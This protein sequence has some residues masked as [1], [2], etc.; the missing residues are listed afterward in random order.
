MWLSSLFGNIALMLSFRL[1]GII[2]CCLVLT[3]CGDVTIRQLGT[4][5][6]QNLQ[7]IAVQDASGREGQLYGRELRKLLHIGG[8]GVEN[9]DL[10]SS[11]SVSASR[12]LS[13]QGASSTLKK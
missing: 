9:Y 10:I 12:T 2:L 13:V 8:K 4:E 1:G 11:I 7:Q 6:L 5:N 3:N